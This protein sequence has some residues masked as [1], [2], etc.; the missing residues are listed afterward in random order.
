M[1]KKLKFIK[2][3]YNFAQKKLFPINRSLTGKGNLKTLHL[4]KKKNNL[5]K[6]KRIKSGTKVFDWK[7][8]YEW[9]VYDAYVLDKNKQKIIDFN[10]NNLH[11][12]GYSTKKKIKLK[13][14]DLLKKIFFLKSRPKAIPYLT[15]YYKKN[16]GFCLSYNDY[17][18]IKNNYKSQDS[19]KIFINTKF[20]KNGNLLYGEALIKGKSKKEILISTYICHPS[21]ANNELSGPIVSLCLLKYFSK[22]KLKKTL[23]FIFISETIGSIAYLAKN[24]NQLKNNLEGGFNLTCIGDNRKHSCLLSKI[25]DS[26]SDEALLDAYKK[27]K[28]NKFKIYSFLERGSDERQYNSP[29]IDLPITSIF[30]TKYGCYPEYHTSEDDFNLVT[31]KGIT[32]GYR[33]AKTAIENLLNKIVPKYKYLCEPQ[34]G[35]RNLYHNISR[36]RTKLP[37]RNI[38][39]FLQYA[40]GYSS[41][42][43]ISKKINL[44]VIKTKKIYLKLKKENL[45]I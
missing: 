6:I 31:V 43:K 30:R 42:K 34:M 41:I 11:L 36:I 35:R 29:G 16:W 8:P 1:K 2:N 39:D 33:V 37:V 4:L 15:S 3:Y 28:I 10:K 25:E 27:L 26:A 17:K 22:K 7:V 5:I 21:M 24:F 13:K 19:F 9:V 20:K 23:R 32:G 40:D 45:I 44:S 14:K 18:K 38:M 12:I